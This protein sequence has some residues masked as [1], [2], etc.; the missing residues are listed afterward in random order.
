[1]GGK[2]AQV[3]PFVV[4]EPHTP[5]LVSPDNDLLI[6]FVHITIIIQ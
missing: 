1:M 4:Q 2:S 6:V 3:R 5:V